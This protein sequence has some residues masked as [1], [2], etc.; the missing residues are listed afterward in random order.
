VKTFVA[1]FETISKNFSIIDL[2]NIDSRMFTTE[3][4]LTEVHNLNIWL[5]IGDNAYIEDLSIV[6]TK[7]FIWQIKGVLVL[8]N[9]SVIGYIILY[10]LKS[11]LAVTL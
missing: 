5:E 4:E 3:T 2:S 10:I 9:K 6:S 7:Q 11:Y 8:Q 1:K